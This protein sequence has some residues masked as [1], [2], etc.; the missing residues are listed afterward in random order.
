MTNEQL[1]EYKEL[2]EKVKALIKTN[3]STRANQV[4]IIA[5]QNIRN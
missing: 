2:S 1:L 4:I 5:E 3:T